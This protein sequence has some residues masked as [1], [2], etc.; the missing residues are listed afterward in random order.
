M[1]KG[2]VN[3]FDTIR[4]ALSIADIVIMPWTSMLLRDHAKK[5]Q[6]VDIDTVSFDLRWRTRSCTFWFDNTLCDL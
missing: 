1:C 6:V 3:D 4:I 2:F 5:G